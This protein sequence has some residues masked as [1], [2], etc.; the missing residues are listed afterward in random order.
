MINKIK[1]IIS[2]TFRKAQKEAKEIQD[3]L[4]Y[5]EYI[6][7]VRKSQE[8]HRL[9]ELAEFITNTKVSYKTKKEADKW[10]A[11]MLALDL[12]TNE[13]APNWSLLVNSSYD[14]KKLNVNAL[15]LS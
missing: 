1:T 7:S 3:H 15:K 4:E 14:L 2:P 10:E 5:L 12:E 11:E 13:V 9:F 6:E 8:I